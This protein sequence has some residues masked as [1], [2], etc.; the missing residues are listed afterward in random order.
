MA[1]T[2]KSLN[3]SISN[4]I[5]TISSPI[6]SNVFGAANRRGFRGA[7]FWYY[8]RVYLPYVFPVI[9]LTFM[10][11]AL[12]ILNNVEGH[13]L[14]GSILS[15]IMTIA[16]VSSYIMIIP[17]RKHPS[18][19]VLYKSLASLV[20]SINIIL[21]AIS[22]T[23]TS[24][25]RN[26]AVVTQWTLMAGECWLTTIAL[27][28]IYSL[29]NP[30][31]SYKS[32]LKRYQVMVWFFAGM[33]SFIFYFN[34]SCQG[35]FDGGIC[36]INITS[37]RSPC[38]WGYYLFWII[39]MYTYQIWAS[40]YAYYRLRKG[41]PITFEI[42]KKCAEETFKCLTIYAIYLSINMFMFAIIST[43]SN[44]EPGSSMGNF[45]L[46]FLFII[47]NRGSVDGI[48]WFMLHDFIRDSNQ[49][50]VTEYSQLEQGGEVGIES[51]ASEDG[52]IRIE[53][54]SSDDQTTDLIRAVQHDSPNRD[55][56]SVNAIINNV[57]DVGEKIGKKVTKTFTKLADL[58]IAELDEADLSPQVN[59]ALRQ[60][61]VQYVT[62]GV[63]NA[64]NNIDTDFK[65]DDDIIHIM[66]NVL[67]FK[68]RDIAVTEG[69]NVLDF[70]LEKEYPFKAFAPEL[71][72]DLRQLEGISDE[73]YLQILT[74]VTN[75]RLS[76]GASGAFMFFCGGGEF[77]VKTIR[78]SEA[79]VLHS[80]L[81]TYI[82][83]LKN[84]RDSLLCRFLGS[85][86]LE[87]YS[88]TFYFVVMLNCFD[89]KAY[90][91]ERF[92]IKGSWVGRSA[93]P[94]KKNKKAVC[95]HCNEYFKASKNEDCK[96]IVG[97]HEANIV[98]K[99]ND[100]RTK[101]SLPP[102][103]ATR[104]VEI[105]KKDSDLLGKLGVMD[106]SLLLGIKKW[107]FE[108]EITQE[109]IDFHPSSN[110]NKVTKNENNEN[111]KSMTKKKSKNNNNNK[112]PYSTYQA[113]TVSGPAIYHLGIVDF[114]Q[115]WTIRKRLERAMKIYLFR[116]D[117]DG[118]SVMEP[119][120]YKLRFQS[121]ME[122]IFDMDGTSGGFGLKND[123][124]SNNNNNN[125][126]MK[127]PPHNVAHNINSVHSSPSTSNPLY[128]LSYVSLEEDEENNNNNNIEYDNSVQNPL[129][130]THSIN[131]SLE[132]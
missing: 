89:P 90:I 72:R 88:Q 35:T 45:S 126:N 36:W 1:S 65:V 41:L 73:Y 127:T 55:H 112:I 85:Y 8:F 110:K 34:S 47:A 22:N 103:N 116:K 111:K 96:A 17:W 16:V 106:Y 63:S 67:K 95:R 50:P 119:E 28:L 113:K 104:V 87:M 98:L 75:E 31:I 40:I 97:K 54:R 130:S 80:S 18:G 10:I 33:I 131:R 120:E 77:I 100:L 23:T 118:L 2:R 124:N 121:K 52:E 6:P 48:V 78:A 42:R 114:L 117:P 92:D 13:L 93:E 115:D 128:G 26:Y 105:L 12:T 46:F 109:M 51:F 57:E 62:L 60:Q 64:V 84:N 82:R 38:L 69:I 9:F 25:C 59:M 30:F 122:Q 15:L 132:F 32:N 99:D 86:S 29:T 107:K 108:V 3:Q 83:Y 68:A 43:N 56:P 74:A 11:I 71:F 4:A 102:T 76:E 61:I 44:A 66:D 70:L 37:T 20:F 123:D 27:D 14:L 91:N 24:S 53:K 5:Q 94:P 21:E 39:L 81:R 101:I 129:Q 7:T 58:A 79:K 49:L 19:L 125:N